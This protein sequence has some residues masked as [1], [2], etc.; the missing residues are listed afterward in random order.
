MDKHNEVLMLPSKCKYFTGIGAHNNKI[1]IK[2]LVINKEFSGY[3][4]LD[5]GFRF[6]DNF[7]NIYISKEISESSVVV[8]VAGLFT[9]KSKLIIDKVLNDIEECKGKRSILDILSDA[10]EPWVM[11]RIKI[12]YY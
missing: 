9:F 8:I 2:S 4:P 3:I 10:V 11:G 5:S 1:N 6:I 12:S 7:S